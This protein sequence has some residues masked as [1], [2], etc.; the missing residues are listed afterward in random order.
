MSYS[1]R[2]NVKG[3]ERCL[4]IG[5]PL[6]ADT[7]VQQVP[8]TSIEIPTRQYHT[9]VGCVVKNTSHLHQPFLSPTIRQKIKG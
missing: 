2:T 9:G 8:T 6:N 1:Q 4:T 5:P 3:V 7:V